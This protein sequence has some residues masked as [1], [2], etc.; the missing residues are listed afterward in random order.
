MYVISYRSK[1]CSHWFSSSVSSLFGL[2][3]F[4]L[5]W[6][7]KLNLQARLLAIC[8]YFHGVLGRAEIAFRGLLDMEFLRQLIGGVFHMGESAE[9][10]LDTNDEYIVAHVAE[11]AEIN[12]FWSFSFPCF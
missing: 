6:I 5:H 11:P 7:P 10:A 3:V 2:P 8:T 12:K 4:L 9:G 1:T